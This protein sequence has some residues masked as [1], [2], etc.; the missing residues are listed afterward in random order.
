LEQI[1]RDLKTIR[2][3][4][5]FNP[6]LGCESNSKSVDADILKYLRRSRILAPWN[7]VLAGTFAR[8]PLEGFNPLIY[9]RENAD[10]DPQGLEDPLAHFARSGRPTLSIA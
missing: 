7:K 8:R 2:R 5:V 1:G 6:S 9:A 10:F 4:R 3:H